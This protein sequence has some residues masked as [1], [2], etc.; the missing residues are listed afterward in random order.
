[1]LDGYPSVDP[2][3][4]GGRGIGREQCGADSRPRRGREFARGFILGIS[5]PKVAVFFVAF[6]PQFVTSGAPAAPQLVALGLVFAACGLACDALRCTASGSSPAECAATAVS[7][8][9]CGVR[10]VLSTWG[11]RVG[12]PF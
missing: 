7:N 6:L 1:M 9:P 12:L 8:A 2:S 10:R 5:N 11:W 3:G 4:Y